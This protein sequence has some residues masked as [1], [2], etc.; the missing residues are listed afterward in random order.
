MRPLL[1]LALLAVAGCS[2]EESRDVA[3]AVVPAQTV[4]LAGKAVW[5]EGIAMSWEGRT[6]HVGDGWEAAQRLF[7]ERRSAYLL[8]SLP[9][10]FGREFQGHGWETN[11][12]QGYGVITANDL[13]VAAIYHA[14]D[15]EEEYAK[16]LLAAQRNGTGLLPMH[17][18]ENGKLLWTFWEDGAQRLMVLFDRG[19]RG[20]DV[21]ILMGDAKV[22]DA[23]GAT[24]PVDTSPSVAPFLTRPPLQGTADLP[25][26]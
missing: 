20:F 10:R 22:L 18:V 15:V 7:P 12:G 11:E 17:E 6:V 8:R 14:E 25:Q 23:L 4:Q 16:S 13:I 19:K 5:T 1:P 2:G 3:L 26:S 21:T 24:R 9:N